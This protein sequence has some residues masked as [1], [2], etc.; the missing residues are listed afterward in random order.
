M[1]EMQVTLVGQPNAG[2]SSLFTRMTGVGVIISNYAGTTVEFEEATVTRNSVSIHVHDLPGTHSLSGNTDDERIVLDALIKDA[3]DAVI[4]V[5]DASN[6]E[7]SIVL[8]FEVMELGLPTILALNKFDL[9]VKKFD[10]DIERMRDIL[11]IPVVPVSARSAMGVDDL[12]DEV[13]S[14]EN[15][16]TDFKVRYDSHIERYLKTLTSVG[17]IEGLDKRGVAVKLLERDAAISSLVS[18]EERDAADK[19]AKEFEITH[20]ESV[21]VHIARDRYGQAGVIKDEVQKK[22]LRE[23]TFSE[24]L[25]DVT[26]AP[27]TG[28]P[29]LIG[30]M[31]VTFLAFIVI[32]GVLESIIQ[33]AYGRFAGGVLSDLGERYGGELGKAI[34]TGID[35]SIR[36]IL[37]LVIPF[38]M[39]FY[40]ILGILEDSGYLPRAVVLLDRTMHSLGLHGGA[41]I[42]MMVGIGCNVPAIL[43]T[44]VIASKRERLILSTII[45]M[46]VPC[47]AQLAIIMGATG[48]YAGLLAAFSIFV[49]LLAMIFLIGILMNKWMRY[50]PTS[51]A[52]EIPDLS[53]PSAKNVLFKTWNRC[54]DF[55]L[56]A[57]PLLVIGSIILEIL[58]VYNILDAIVGPFSFMTVTML[59]LPSIV[60][61]AFVMG[62][63]RKEMA[64][65]MLI[66]LAMQQGLE[67]TD[68]MSPDQFLVFGLVM[69]IYIPCLA[70]MAVL[71]KEFGLRNTV[72]ICG[73]SLIVALFIGTAFNAILS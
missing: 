11:G 15:K 67:L 37:T 55:F 33:D 58:L 41:F 65:G 62:I 43:A 46:A 4:V 9:A 26:T 53:M 69:A 18:E 27:V 40:V 57:F 50:E 32:S 13:I 29:I 72:M 44:R 59:G 73:T 30:V 42:P 24:K 61:I 12:L 38:I 66:I 63:V 51:L 60:I 25:S 19:M 34:M 2:K 56:L 39:L 7:G 21:N 45:V 31:F 3:G 64:L 20:G 52:M 36:A 70:T 54:K 8:C 48:K 22:T 5:A 10:T 16:R 71:W 47:S 14:Y 28:I 35:G 23:R 17:D 68:F 49:V 1:K 6:I